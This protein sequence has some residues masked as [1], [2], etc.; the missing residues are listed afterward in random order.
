MEPAT[1]DMRR[2]LEEWK[3]MRARKERARLRTDKRVSQRGNMRP[4][5]K[6]P[7]DENAGETMCQRRKA[8]GAPSPMTPG[9]KRMHMN[10]QSP[11]M[12]ICQNSG[13]P[14]MDEL[15][16]ETR[17]E[18]SP[19]QSRTR[20]TGTE[21]V[22]AELAAWEDSIR[23]PRPPPSSPSTPMAACMLKIG[24]D[25]KSPSTYLAVIEAVSDTL[26]CDSPPVQQKLLSRLEEQ[27]SSEDE[28]VK[29]PLRSCVSSSSRLL[30]SPLEERHGMDQ[31]RVDGC[32]GWL[33]N[34]V[35]RAER[36]EEVREER[37]E[38]SEQHEVSPEVRVREDVSETDDG[39]QETSCDWDDD[40]HML[41]IDRL[42]RHRVSWPEPTCLTME[43]H[44]SRAA[45]VVTF[46]FFEVRDRRNLLFMAPEVPQP[47]PTLH[48][49]PPGWPRWRIKS[50]ELRESARSA[51][52]GAQQR[53]SSADLHEWSI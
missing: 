12:E 35:E 9:K 26:A 52:A 25:F 11:L 30:F 15:R 51:R 45:D 14:W 22:D 18:V 20:N 7:S 49:H 41:L 28:S 31:H 37:Q 21:A 39:G 27:G 6:P 4:H 42:E 38:E 29:S 33:E 34:S 2:E 46:W 10:A 1:R 40:E 16:Q 13:R 53:P 32:Q 17:P 3:Q 43:D 8:D 47:L 24:F 50:V 44:L 23:A 36:P 48:E 19:V 5:R